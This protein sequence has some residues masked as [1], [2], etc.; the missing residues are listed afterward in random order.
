MIP[1]ILLFPFTRLRAIKLGTYPISCAFSKIFLRV[2][3]FTFSLPLS[4]RFTV[5][6]DTPQASATS[7][8][9]TAIFYQSFSLNYSLFKNFAF[10]NSQS[11]PHATTSSNPP[12]LQAISYLTN[13]FSSSSGVSTMQPAPCSSKNA[14]PRKPQLTKIPSMPAC[15]AVSTSTSE[16]PI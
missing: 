14:L 15:F 8:A 9:V 12:K 16:S 3:G 7:F 6:R 4:A 13:S 1:I 2:S 10:Y 5:I 11:L